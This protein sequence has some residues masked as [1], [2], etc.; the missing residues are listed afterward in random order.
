M[1]RVVTGIYA[2]RGRPVNAPSARG[3]AS[4]ELEDLH[5]EEFVALIAKHAGLIAE[6]EAARKAAKR[7]AANARKKRKAAE[8]AQQQR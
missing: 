5:Q 1:Q 8:K 7:K 3:R 2:R 4:R 6:E